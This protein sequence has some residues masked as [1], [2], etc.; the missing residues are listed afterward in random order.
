VIVDLR[1]RGAGTEGVQRADE[2]VDVASE[3]LGHEPFEPDG[4]VGEQ[5]V[6]DPND[7]PVFVIPKNRLPERRVDAPDG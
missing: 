3:E 4:L 5:F 2:L 7:L 6:G 1:L